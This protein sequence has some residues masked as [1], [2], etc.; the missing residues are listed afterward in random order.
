MR[1]IYP[2][3]PPRVEYQ[4]TEL[5][6]SFLVPM[7]KLVIWADTNHR[8]VCEAREQ[9]VKKTALEA[10]HNQKGLNLEIF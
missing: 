10:I 1:T 9:Y 4:L 6:R 2:E 5:G 7:Q 8:A 3:V